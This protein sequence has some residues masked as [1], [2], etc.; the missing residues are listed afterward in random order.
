M[1]MQ[2]PT[3]FKGVDSALWELPFRKHFPS[4]FFKH[5]TEVIVFC[6]MHLRYVFLF[7]NQK[8]KLTKK[9]RKIPQTIR[10]LHLPSSYLSFFWS[11][12]EASRA[13]ANI[14][15]VFPLCQGT[16]TWLITSRRPIILEISNLRY[17]SAP[18]RHELHD[19]HISK[20]YYSIPWGV[21]RPFI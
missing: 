12:L 7:L 4:T 1:R 9:T 11:T 10:K 14:R 17:N 18:K 8:K 21:R 19:L 2:N 3:N 13:C 6:C 15:P 20:V 5:A 16:S